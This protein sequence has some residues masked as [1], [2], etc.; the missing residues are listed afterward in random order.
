M[1]DGTRAVPS[2]EILRQTALAAVFADHEGVIRLWNAA[3]AALFGYTADEA[4]GHRVDLV[5]PPEHHD[6]HWAGF[7]R[8]VRTGGMRNPDP[9][10]V[11]PGRTRSGEQIAVE[12]AFNVITD[13]H[14]R[15]LGVVAL[16]RGHVPADTEQL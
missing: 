3:A 5:I 8:A 12:G 1:C 15:V 10:A 11:L 14:G 7:H 2:A 16:L 13:E 6:R 9:F 4:I